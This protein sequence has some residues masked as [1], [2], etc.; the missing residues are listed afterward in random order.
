M[1]IN[2]ESLFSSVTPSIFSGDFFH[3]IPDLY[4]YSIIIYLTNGLIKP[5]LTL[6]KPSQALLSPSSLS[7]SI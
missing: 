6:Q 5:L 2:I 4:R 7:K 1:E 3:I